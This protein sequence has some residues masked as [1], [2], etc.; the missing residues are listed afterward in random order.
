MEGNAGLSLFTKRILGA[1]L[2]FGLEHGSSWAE[3]VGLGF[4]IP[5]AEI[6]EPV[7]LAITLADRRIN[8]LQQDF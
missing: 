3:K 6:S 5:M 8:S 2:D 4:E 1:R 7:S